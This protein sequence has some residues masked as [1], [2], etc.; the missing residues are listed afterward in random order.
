MTLRFDKVARSAGLLRSMKTYS[1]VVAEDFLY[2]IVTGSAGRI[3]NP[4][5]LPEDLPPVPPQVAEVE[6]RITPATLDALSQV[7]HGYK[8]ALDEITSLRLRRNVY[9]LP[10]L[11]L[12]S[13]QGSFTFEFRAQGFE[14]VEGLVRALEASH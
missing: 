9:R 7:K 10:Q 2:L 4:R 1:L 6:A 8:I 12:K 5:S 13:S 11:K 3:H 14:E